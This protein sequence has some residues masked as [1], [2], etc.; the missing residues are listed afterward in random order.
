VSDAQGQ[1]VFL[2]GAG[3]AMDAGLPSSVQLAEHLY[4]HLTHTTTAPNDSVAGLLP[5]LNFIVGGIRFQ[6]GI[7]N[8]DPRARI[9]IEQIANAAVRLAQ[10]HDNPVAPYTS[11]WHRRI[12]ELENAYPNVLNQFVDLTYSRLSSEL[13]PDPSA[14]LSYLFRLD[15]FRSV[16]PRVDVFTLNY[17]LCIEMSFLR[18]ANGKLVTGFSD[19]GW[20]PALLQCTSGIRLLKLHGSLD[21]VND[22]EH[23]ICAVE[24]PGHQSLTKADVPSRPLLIFGTDQKTSGLD[25]F[26]TLLYQFSEALNRAS[27]L[28]IVGY[29]FGDAYINEMVQQRLAT[30]PR[31]RIVVVAPDADAVIERTEWLKKRPLTVRS[32]N[33]TARKA[34]QDMSLKQLV[35]QLVEDQAAKPP[36]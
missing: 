33:F 1:I 26:L 24:Y 22:E 7:L 17:D 16:T 9:N 21:W 34:L 5:A 28:V 8:Q 20:E 29:S 36:F 12:D 31:L 27:V 13:T 6:Q 11:G 2:C 30:N 23:G 14:D 10:R 15:D 35:S 19:V 32:M 4:E 25:P 3:L 18:F